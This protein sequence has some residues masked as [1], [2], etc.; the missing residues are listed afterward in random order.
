MSLEWW[1]AGKYL[2]S[3]KGKGLSVISWIALF[4][5]IVGSMSLVCVLAVMSGFEKEL[6]SKILGN[7]AHL[8]INSFVLGED[9]QKEFQDLL[10]IVRSAD[11]VESAMAVIYGEAFLLGSAS[12]GEAAFIKIVD[13]QEVRHVLDLGLY[14]SEDNWEAFEKGGIIVGRSLARRLGVGPGD[15]LTL[16]LNQADFSPLGAVPRMQRFR[17]ADVF[18]SGMTQYDG[19]HVYMPMEVGVELFERYP[20]QIEV[21]TQSFDKIASVRRSLVK[22]IGDRAEIQDWLALNQDFL[23]ALRLEKTVMA[24]ILG[25]IILVAAFNISG[26]LIMVVRDK[27]KDIAIMKSMGATD[28]SILKIFFTQGLFIGL[29]GTIVG[30]LLGIALSYLL[31]YHIQFPLNPDVYMIDQVPVDLRIT[32]IVGVALGAVAISL[33]A[34]LYPAKLAASLDPVEGLKVD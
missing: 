2:G 32:D 30:V 11:H 25:L 28:R 5:V 16:L 4:G 27:T 10:G 13:P 1:L 33:V 24:I 21:R 12:Q 7:N 34:T 31:R 19:S 23:S 3:K 6:R 26:S 18:H 14:T 8:L 29:V 15:E 9:R 20:N 22:T 17:V